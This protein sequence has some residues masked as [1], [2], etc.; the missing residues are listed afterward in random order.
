[1]GRGNQAREAFFGNCRIADGRHRRG[2]HSRRRH[3]K[4]SQTSEQNAA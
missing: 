2:R 1:M 3:G 4:P